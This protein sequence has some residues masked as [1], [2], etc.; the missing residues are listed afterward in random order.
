[1]PRGTADAAGISVFCRKNR[2]VRF[3]AKNIF[4]QARWNILVEPWNL[5][6]APTYNDHI[7][8][9]KV[10]HLRQTPRKTV[11]ESL[12]RSQRGR[13][14]RAASGDDF[15]TLQFN[16]RRPLV[17]RFQTSSGDPGFQTA[18]SSAVARRTGKFPL[19]HPR[20]S[21]MSPF[22]GH[23]VRTTVYPAIDRNS[24]ATS[25]AQNHGEDQVLARTSAIRRF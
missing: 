12:Q 19:P 9:E 11:F 6:S 16:A 2:C 14:S 3:M 17:V 8:I 18:I 21:V 5:R 23:T 25:S 22:A 4:L 7:G 20:Q 10:D 13:L 15:G 24:T 1:E